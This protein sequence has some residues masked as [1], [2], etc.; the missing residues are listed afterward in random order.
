M[1]VVVC[2]YCLLLKIVLL[3]LGLNISSIY[4]IYYKIVLVVLGLNISS[5]YLHSYSINGGRGK[6]I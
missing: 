3:G 4:I 2:Y 6:L 1:A 5:I